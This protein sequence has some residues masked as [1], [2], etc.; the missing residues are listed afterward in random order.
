V[1]AIDAKAEAVAVSRSEYLRTLILSS[2]NKPVKEAT[3]PSLAQDPII[4]LQHIVYALHRIHS[5]IY[6]IPEASGT[7]D[8]AQLKS[9][10]DTSAQRGVEY[11]AKLDQ[12][13][14][15]LRQEL[16]GVVPSNGTGQ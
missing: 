6:A 10:Y 8:L 16:S 4:L 15:Q 3:G 9:I 14:K 7:P 13:L 1:A 11:L 2:L 12:H 5:A